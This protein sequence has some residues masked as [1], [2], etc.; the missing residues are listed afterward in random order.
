MDPMKFFKLVPAVGFVWIAMLQSFASAQLTAD[1][2]L[3]SN[4]SQLFRNATARRAAQ[5]AIAD[6]NAVLNQNLGRIA[7]GDRTIVGSFGSTDV[8]I[9]LTGEVTN[10]TTGNEVPASLA[11]NQSV[12]RIF[13]GARQL[14]GNIAGLAGPDSPSSRIQF[15]GFPNQLQAALSRAENQTNAIYSR[16]EG[17]TIFASN[18]S[19]GGVAYQL[20]FGLGL[21]SIA[22]DD[23]IG[24]FHLDHTTPPASNRVDLY[25]VVLHEALHAI[26]VGAS[27]SWRDN[28]TGSSWSGM[29]VRSLLG[30]GTNVVSSDGS[31]IAMGVSRNMTPRI[32]DGVLQQSVFTPLIST[33]TRFVLTELDLA[34]LR[35]IG[36][37]GAVVPPRPPLAGDFDDDGDIDLADLDR[38]N[39]NLGS[40]ATGS[41]AALDLNG[42][43][44]VD[45]S[46]FETHYTTLVRTSNGVAG[47]V[48]GDINLDG[49]VNVLGD[50][51]VMVANLGNESNSWGQGDLNAD[52]VVNVLGDAFL[53]VGNLGASQ[54]QTQSLAKTSVITTESA[55]SCGCSC[56]SKK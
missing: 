36:F 2:S 43:G 37:T 12:V 8:T 31:H 11:A 44:T 47:T 39:N 50:A 5:A 28:V 15:L 25:S 20:N 38:Y 40:P 22:I 13:V 27:Q 30:S 33:G 45:P 49:I 14:D 17:P 54:S 35:D 46:D 42:N 10:P 29:E 1:F 41:L 24:R 6:L 16:G 19:L 32:T 21:A 7:A 23:E 3:D 9:T 26:G 51:F 34:I 48:L 4:R 18:G 55:V 52:G 53:L 56:C